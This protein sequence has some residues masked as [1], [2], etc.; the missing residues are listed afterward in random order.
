[1]N[2]PERC[3]K[4][5]LGAGPLDTHGN[6]RI[7]RFKRLAEALGELEI[8]RR[9]ERKLALFFSPPR[10]MPASPP[11]AAGAAATRTAKA[12]RHEPPGSLEH[13]AFCELFAH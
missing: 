9:V 5:A 2:I 10:S 13:I 7:L 12:L 11:H 4:D 8:H 6:A 3:A 1:M